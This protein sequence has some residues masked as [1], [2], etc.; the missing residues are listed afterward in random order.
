MSRGHTEGHR[1]GHVK[2]EAEIRVTQPHAKGCLESPEAGKR[3]VRFPPCAFGES[4]A[5]LTP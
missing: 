5:L 2:M 1:E 3:E 4:T